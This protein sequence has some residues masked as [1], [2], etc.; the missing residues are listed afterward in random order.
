MK[1]G[2]KIV[3]IRI[4]KLRLK[5]FKGIKEL[6]INFEGKNTNIYGKNATGKTTIFDAFKWLFFDKDSS[7][8]KDF[9]IKTLDENNNAIHYLE[10]EVEATLLIDNQE[11]IFKKMLEEKWVKKRGQEQQEFS[12][13]ETNYWIDEVPVKKK[14]YEEKI[15]SIIPENL[16]KL[17]T[18]PAFFNKMLWKEK[19]ELLIN[20]SG[21]NISDEQI[22][23]SNEQFN[24][25][26]ENLQGRSTEDYKKVIQAK[27]KELNNKKEKIPVRIDEL[28]QT[29]ITEHNIDYNK[30]E[31]EKSKYNKEL[32]SIENKM[33][34]VQARAKENINKVSELSSAKNELNNLKFKLETEHSNKNSAEQINLTNEKAVLESKIRA[35]KQELEERQHK[36]EQDTKKRDELRAKW[37]EVH[38]T[39]LEFD[40]N[41]LICP[42]C[43]REY[44]Q[45]KIEKLRETYKQEF[46]KHQ[47]EEK[48]K[49]NNEGQA[50]STTLEENN[51]AIERLQ[52][53][54]REQQQ[55]LSKIYEKLEE[56]EK[57]K[58]NQEAFD[59]TQ[60]EE[61][62]EKAAQVETLE[63]EVAK[64]TSEDTTEMQNKKAHIIEQINSINKKLNERDIQEKTKARI[65]ELEKQEQEMS[66]KIQELEAQ[67]YQIEQF[68]KTK[69]ELLE[70]TINSNFEIVKFRLF[71]TQINRRTRGVL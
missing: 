44:E 16:F 69:V 11:T 28:S 13:H 17:I 18:D 64:L 33:T 58:E 25:L 19:R 46:E 9:N 29:L 54:I 48:E 21:N 20:I 36:V 52:S 60:N 42:S 43:K 15:N 71:K 14:D 37:D 47:Q 45:E 4:Q 8:R 24:I 41:L 55:E 68:T 3:E 67:Q 59:V 56:I 27:I 6:E 23:N 49:I 70:N 30:L 53:V 31:E 7:D 62:K 35:N 61:Y 63:Q 34:D 38:N 5:N 65:E 2:G 40:E 26:K 12:G 32:Q 66:Q 51:L 10:H 50:I 57:Q 39:K 1:K 22:L